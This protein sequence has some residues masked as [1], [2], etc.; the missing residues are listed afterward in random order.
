MEEDEMM[1]MSIRL[2]LIKCRICGYETTD[3]EDFWKHHIDNHAQYFPQYIKKE[4]FKV[5]EK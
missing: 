2:V 4:Y 3:E 5:V 1:D